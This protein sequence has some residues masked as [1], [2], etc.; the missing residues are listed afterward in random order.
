MAV[1]A[2]VMA[3]QQAV[4]VGWLQNGRYRLGQH[5]R[6]ILAEMQTA[7]FVSLHRALDDEFRHLQQVAQLDQI[8]ADAEI[9]IELMHFVAQHMNAVQGAHQ[10]FAGAYDTDVIPHEAA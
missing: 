5:V 7:T 1:M 3:V 8:I 9:A 6:I 10:A 4:I 2:A